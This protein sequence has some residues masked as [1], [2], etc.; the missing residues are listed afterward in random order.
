MVCFKAKFTGLPNTPQHLIGKPGKPWFPVYLLLIQSISHH[1]QYKITYPQDIPIISSHFPYQKKTQAEPRLS[2]GRGPGQP[3]DSSH[4][5]DAGDD[6]TQD[7]GHKDEQKAHQGPGDAPAE[8]PL[9]PCHENPNKQSA[10]GKAQI[11]FYGVIIGEVGKYHNT[12]I[13]VLNNFEKEHT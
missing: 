4:Q 1:I 3:A 12:F 5:Q 10:N 11:G 13:F 9:A 7:E 2:D 6:R 8:P